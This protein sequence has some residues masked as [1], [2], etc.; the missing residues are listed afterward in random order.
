MTPGTYARRYCKAM[1]NLMDSEMDLLGRARVDFTKHKHAEAPQQSNGWDCG[2][3][4]LSTVACLAGG[5]DIAQQPPPSG[6]GI[7]Q[8]CGAELPFRCTRP[9][10]RKPGAGPRPAAGLGTAGP[11]RAELQ[12]IA[13]R[14]G[15]P[16]IGFGWRYKFGDLSHVSEG[17]RISL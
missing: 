9:A 2:V 8:P 4:V 17:L 12:R 5:V 3:F 7:C 14:L 15:F 13:R 10:V 16:A 11:G 1:Q 6:S